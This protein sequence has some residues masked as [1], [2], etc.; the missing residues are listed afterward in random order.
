MDFKEGDYVTII[1]EPKTDMVYGWV[2]NMDKMC[3]KTYPIKYV[4]HDPGVLTGNGYIVNGW[5][6][7]A[8][9]F[10]EY[11]EHPEALTEH[12]YDLLLTEV[13]L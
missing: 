9:C 2:S 4:L 11:Y 1:D 7:T 3:G 6:F 10:R 12:D 5:Q 8:D 13:I